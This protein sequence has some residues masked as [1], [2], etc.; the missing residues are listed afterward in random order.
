VTASLPDLADLTSRDYQ[1]GFVTDIDTD[2]APRG[3]S[4]DVIRLISEKKEEPDWLL[5]W[6]LS[7]YRHWLTMS[8]PTWQNVS[9][10]LLDYDDIIYYAAP[11]S[12]KKGPASLDDVDPEV[13]AMFD[14]L[15]ISLAEQ[16]RL[17][18]VAVDAVVDS[19]SVVTT[20]Q[21]KLAEA[22]VIFCEG[23][24]LARIDGVDADALGLQVSHGGDQVDT[25]GQFD[26]D[27]VIERLRTV[28]DPEIPINVV[29]L[30]LV[31][32]CQ[33]KSLPDGSKRV[34]ITM[35]MTAPG[36]GMGDVLR[37]EAQAK[38][39]TLPGVAEVEVEIVWDPPWD[40]SRLSDEAR[41]QLGMA[42]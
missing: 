19:V 38:V 25:G 2:L 28:Y 40:L 39:E 32:S 35:S 8:E 42:W 1:Y 23:G 33:A 14:K 22:G 6:R 5:R 26:I 31:Y 29:D 15:G 27:Q 16:E 21:R 10:G 4:G 7:A 34:E 30:G 20:F 37:E 17:S 24:P 36:C 18:G 11:K 9:Y 13:R 12:K 3:L 41:L